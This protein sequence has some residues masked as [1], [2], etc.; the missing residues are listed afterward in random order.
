MVLEIVKKTNWYTAQPQTTPLTMTHS[1]ASTCHAPR[2]LNNPQTKSKGHLENG[3]CPRGNTE[4]TLKEWRFLPSH[5]THT[6]V[7]DNRTLY[8]LYAG[9]TPSLLQ[10]CSPLPS[11]MS[12]LSTSIPVRAELSSNGL[13]VSHALLRYTAARA[14][15]NERQEVGCGGCWYDTMR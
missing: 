11:R 7:S 12:V 3:D 14:Q 10:G 8:S 1:M 9:L 13:R 5:T 15:M 2:R 4:Q 6:S